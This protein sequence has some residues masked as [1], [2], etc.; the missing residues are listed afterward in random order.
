[1][2]LTK[3]K[4]FLNPIRYTPLII[5]IL[6]A[7]SSLTTKIGMSGIKDRQEVRANLYQLKS[8]I[9]NANIALRNAGIA[10]TVYDASKEFDKMLVTRSSANKIF[11]TL[12]AAKLTH[13]EK[14][15]LA[16][17]KNER[18][19]YREAQLK[20]VDFIKLQKKQEAW[21]AMSYY[22]TLMDRY[23]QRVD[24]LLTLSKDRETE[25]FADTRQLSILLLV[26]SFTIVIYM[27]WRVD[28]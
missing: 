16:E 1:V 27:F 5:L 24:T 11:D 7:I 10:V 26:F 2:E 9:L 21:V 6:L 13:K 15:I 20:V 28:D 19:E 8:D 3:I 18:P 12:S 17:M 23:V 25:I 22:Q 4:N 14:V